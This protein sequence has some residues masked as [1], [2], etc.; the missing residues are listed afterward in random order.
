MYLSRVPLIAVWSMNILKV[1]LFAGAGY[2]YLNSNLDYHGTVNAHT[3]SLGWLAAASYTDPLSENLG[4]AGEI[5]W[6]NAVENQDVVMTIQ[7]QLV[8]KLLEW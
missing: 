1:D 8:W 7:V 6:M 4:V 5:K 2:Y 3:W